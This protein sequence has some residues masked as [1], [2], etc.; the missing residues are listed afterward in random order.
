MS[1]SGELIIKKSFDYPLPL[2]L[3][4]ISCMLS[5]LRDLIVLC[6]IIL[7]HLLFQVT[8]FLSMTMVCLNWSLT[9]DIVLVS[10]M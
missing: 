4:H 1:H 9:A 8:M 7:F 5:G 3:F 10:S 6:I 2:L